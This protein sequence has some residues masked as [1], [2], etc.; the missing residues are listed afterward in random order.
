MKTLGQSVYFISDCHLGQNDRSLEARKKELLIRLFTEIQS[1]KA[2]LVINGD[3]FDFWFDYGTVIPKRCF[4][5]CYEL[6]KLRHAGIEIDLIAGNHDY[7]MFSFF[8]EE[9]GIRVHREPLATVRQGRKIL[10]AHGDGLAPKDN[11]YRLIKQ[12]FRH[13]LAIFLYRW[14]HPDTGIW[15]ADQFSKSSRVYTTERE[16]SNPNLAPPVYT[17]VAHQLLKTGY[18]IVVFGHTHKPELTEFPEGTYL[19]IGNWIT[20]FSYGVLADGRLTL[21]F[22]ETGITN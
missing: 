22:M 9:M 3:L 12:I 15:L 1:K 14:L 20:E 6:Q 18:D 11:G 7:W 4:W 19:N 2:D 5:V 13:P 16:N 21:N 8:Q 10:V 17:E